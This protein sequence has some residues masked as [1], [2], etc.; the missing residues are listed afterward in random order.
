VDKR[1]QV[2]ACLFGN[3]TSTSTLDLKHTQQKEWF[4]L[5]PNV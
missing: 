3:S 1:A 4:S 5:S 2:M